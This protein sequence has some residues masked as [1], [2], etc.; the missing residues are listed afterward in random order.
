[1]ARKTTKD[2]PAEAAAA[3]H[4]VLVR[5]AN[6]DVIRY[7]P[8]GLVM[9]LSDKVI[10]DIALRLGTSPAG[11]AQAPGGAAPAVTRADPHE[12]LEGIDA[13]DARIDGDWLI[14]A[15]RLAGRQGIRTFRRPLSGGDI[16]A[17]APGP[18]YGVLAIGG[19]RAALATPGGCAF[20][21]HVLAPADDIGAVGHAGVERAGTHDRLEH[22]REMTH[23]ALVAETLLG[24]QLEK[25]EALPLFL[26]RAETDSS[27]TSADLATGRAYKNLITA[28][29]NLSRAAAALG[30]RAKIL[31][32]HLDFALEDMSG[33]AAAYRDGILALMAQTE[34]DLGQLGF[35]KPLFVARFESGGPEVATEAAIEGQW[36]L[37]WNYADHR[38]IFSAPG[39]MFAQDDHD[40]PT[41]AARREMAEMTAAAISAADDWRCPT[42]HLAERSSRE[43]GSIIRVVAQAA[44]DLV[45]DKDDP[46]GAGK[47]AGFTLVGAEN[48]ARITTVK[49]DPGDPKSLLLACSKAPEGADLRVAYAFGTGDRGCGSVRDDWQMQ[50]ATGR[51]LHRWAL[52]CLLPVRD[53]DGDA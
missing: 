45:I 50:G 16:I 8:S 17:D 1:M 19:P 9:R 12:L 41:E 31:A 42:F 39:Y 18:L 13:W 29:A 5:A 51:S 52:P 11:Q 27:A 48:G 10:D 35:D 20:P 47:T 43:G 23:E 33:S 4:G 22:L 49:I 30:K 34:R 14:F 44:G 36:E 46:L 28:A 15:A 38:L 53:G 6:G 40:R 21:Q 7:D 26:T 3:G 25:F 24:W 37:I 2:D 32:I